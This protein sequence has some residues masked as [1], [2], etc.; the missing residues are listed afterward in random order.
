V[1]EFDSWKA[2][3]ECEDTTREFFR[4]YELRK[5][6]SD[7]QAF[8]S[9]YSTEKANGVHFAYSKDFTPRQFEFLFDLI[10]ERTIALEYISYVSDR[11]IYEKPEFIETVEKHY[12]KPNFRINTGSKAHQLYGNIL[13]EHVLIDENPSY[14]KILSTTYSDSNYHDPLPFEEFLKK[15]FNQ[16]G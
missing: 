10:Q 13:I 4:Q 3:N 12:L 5:Y 16:T 6:Y 8:A 11:M 15:I 9:L 14:L 2:T 7:H 1:K